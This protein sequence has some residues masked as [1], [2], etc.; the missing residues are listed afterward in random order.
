MTLRFL[1]LARRGLLEMGEGSALF[2]SPIA[3]LLRD[4]TCRS[5]YA[6]DRLLPDDLRTPSMLHWTPL[7]V[8]AQAARWIDEMGIRTVLDIGSGAGKFCV[9]A[10][11][12]GG[13]GSASYIGIEQR[14]RLVVASRELAQTLEVDDRVTFFQGTFG[15]SHLP[16]ADAYYMYNPFGENLFGPQS[17]IDGDVEL[18]LE[19]YRRDIVA[20]EA[21]LKAAPVGTYLLTYNGFGGAV[22]SSFKV[23]RVDRELPNVLQMWKKTLPEAPQKTRSRRDLPSDYPLG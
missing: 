5:D 6:F 12:A 19:R 16:A 8:A 10:A 7:F 17:Q 4:N 13:S 9:A 23:I 14:A 21:M 15:P 11:L 1:S 22:P 18:S 2:T 20:T 3:E